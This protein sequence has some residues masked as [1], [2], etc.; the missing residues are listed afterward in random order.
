MVNN[1]NTRMS[2]YDNNDYT[3]ISNMSR[4]KKN[5]SIY[6]SDDMEELSKFKTSDNVSII[7]D[8]AKDINIDTIRDFINAKDD[9]KE[10][11][12]KRLDIDLPEVEEKVVE[13]QE[14]RTYDIN[15]VLENA[16]ENKEIDYDEQRHRKINNTQYDILKN[17]KIHDKKEILEKES[18][19]LN[20]N[21]KTI[22][23]LIQDIQNKPKE[24]TSVSDLFQDLMS[25]HENT[26][27]MAPIDEDDINKKNMKETLANITL[28]LERIK[29]PIN[30][31]TQDLLI[32]KE[33]LKMEE[34]KREEEKLKDQVTEERP[35]AKISSIDKSFYTNSMT[36]TK[37]DFEGFED[38][39]KGTT[40]FTRVAIIVAVLLLIVTVFLILNFSMGWNII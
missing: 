34:K 13:R 19:E 11:K 9:G 17:I 30:D 24:D 40:T 14:F 25:D 1:M 3:D 5:Q 21:E 6:N 18:K 16:R 4:V 20:T 22:V 36:F 31:E 10:E 7:S 23:D 29:E 35:T 2:K 28:D 32:E 38:I 33:K 8:E 15:S 27:V 39:E 26:I 37:T 12:R